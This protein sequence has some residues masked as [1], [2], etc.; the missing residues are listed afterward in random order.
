MA[1]APDLP[2]FR[3]RDALF[4]ALRA[5]VLAVYG[6][7]LTALAVFG[8][9]AR[10][11]ATPESDLD[12]LVVA[13]SLPPSR[14]KRVREFRPVEAATQTARDLVWGPNRPAIELAP[15]FKTPEELA[16]GSPLYLD[17]TLWCVVLH[18]PDHTLGDYLTGLEARMKALGSTRKTFKGGMFWDYKPDFRPGEVVEL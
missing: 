16:A 4:A 3:H 7:R 8:S 9:W 6:E 2:V 12:L 1:T 13:E 15:V 10:G 14:M 11:T 5:A 18:D 17:M